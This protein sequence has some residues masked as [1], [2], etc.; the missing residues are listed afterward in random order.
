MTSLTKCPQCGGEVGVRRTCPHCGAHA[1]VTT[2][3]VPRKSDLTLL[4]LGAA[5][6]AAGLMALVILLTVIAW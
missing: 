6:F 5:V 4:S 3:A 2:P 1:Q